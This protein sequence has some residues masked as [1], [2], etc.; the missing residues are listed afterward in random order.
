MTTKLALTLR[1]A[2]RGDGE[3][4]QKDLEEVG[5]VA[6]VGSNQMRQ[7]TNVDEDATEFSIP[8][9]GYSKK[10]FNQVSSGVG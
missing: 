5:E 4:V 1:K 10:I 3:E 7:L 2:L 8:L 9:K 6:G